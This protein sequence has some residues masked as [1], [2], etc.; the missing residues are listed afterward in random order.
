MSARAE[1]LQRQPARTGRTSSL[2]RNWHGLPV[3]AWVL[4]GTVVG[5][6][7]W[8]RVLHKSS[9]PSAATPASTT[10]AAAT[11]GAVLPPSSGGGGYGGGGVT[12][13]GAQTGAPLS[14]TPAQPAKTAVAGA[15][16]GAP[17]GSVFAATGHVYSPISTWKHTLALLAEGVPVFL[18]TTQTG[19]AYPVTAAQLKQI[20]H[21]G[22]HAFP[23][24][25]TYTE[26]TAAKT[27]AVTAGSTPSQTVSTTTKY[28]P[29]GSAFTQTSRY[30]PA[31]KRTVIVSG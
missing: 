4:G 21:T 16:Q 6:L 15:F 27:S 23:Q 12:T 11:P 3:W 28:R 25:V 2:T 30:T 10:V 7:V 18:R 29:T 19:Q 20:E 26:T 31:V 1:T 13:V 8:T 9:S 24:Y 14:T 22:N 5:Y 17:T